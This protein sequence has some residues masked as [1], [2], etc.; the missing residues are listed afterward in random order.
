MRVPSDGPELECRGGGWL[1]RL[2]GAPCRAECPAPPARPEPPL[3]DVPTRDRIYRRLLELCPVSAA[4]HDYLID[5][6]GLPADAPTDGFGSLP[7]SSGQTVALLEAE[8]GRAALLTVPGFTAHDGRLHIGGA[9]LLVAAR[10]ADGRIVGC[11][12]R[13]GPRK[14]IWLSGNG[15]PRCGAPVHVAR[16]ATPSGARAYI[17]E[18]GKTA[19]VLAHRLGAVVIGLGGLSNASGIPAALEALQ[20]A[21]DGV[22]IAL[23]ADPPGD[24]TGAQ[25]LERARRTLAEMAAAAGYRVRIARWA[26]ADGKGPDDL[27][28][29]GQSWTLETYR[30]DG[31]EPGTPRPAAPR[32]ETAAPSFTA[33]LSAAGWSPLLQRVYTAVCGQFGVT[34]GTPYADGRPAPRVIYGRA[35]AALTDD[36]INKVYAAL[37]ALVAAH[38][39]SREPRY[40]RDP[41]GHVHE[42]RYE[43]ALPNEPAW[44]AWCDD[45]SLFRPGALRTDLQEKA[46]RAALR[47]ARADRAAALADLRAADVALLARPHDEDTIARHRAASA[48]YDAACAACQPGRPGRPRMEARSERQSTPDLAERDR[49]NPPRDRGVFPVPV[50]CSLLPTV[51]KPPRVFPVDAP[52]EPPGPDTWMHPMQRLLRRGGR[53]LPDPDPPSDPA[54]H[55]RH[56]DHPVDTKDRAA[57]DGRTNCTQPCSGNS[58]AERQHG[59]T[60]ALGP[61]AHLGP[62]APFPCYDFVTNTCAAGIMGATT[63]RETSRRNPSQRAAT[64]WAARPVYVDPFGRPVR[65]GEGP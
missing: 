37:E 8:F 59:A 52:A 23:D 13:V 16:P 34:P 43:Y 30:P 48:A 27:L 33:A 62:A 57:P 36:H 55:L 40:G 12:V 22:V 7:E 10:D 41:A 4:H 21:I 53:P 15:G 5:R 29:G 19:T 47:V 26:Y 61:R 60:T 9:G 28:L 50:D 11:Q 25:R 32:D 20:D 51:S 65:P 63:P 2:D 46:R 42:T 58:G 38:F 6:C 3:A 56:A 45:P 17:V 14:Y 49:E 39:L 31:P 64:A 1:H 18:S 24:E 54:D 35:I 44:A